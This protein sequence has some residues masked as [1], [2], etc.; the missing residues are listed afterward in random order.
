LLGSSVLVDGSFSLDVIVPAGGT[1]APLTAE[2][3]T[4]GSYKLDVPD[5][6]GMKQRL[7]SLSMRNFLGVVD[8]AL[9]RSGHTRR[10]IGYLNILHMKRS[11][12]DYVVNELGLRPDQTVYLS[13]YGHMGQQDQALSIRLGLE[14]GRL[15]D[16]DLM[17]MVAAG[18][19]YAW[20]ASVVQWGPVQPP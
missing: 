3:L 1:R 9:A 18:I 4:D 19:G 12:H 11:A 6:E 5:P 2:A 7:D 14:T 8:S 20:S 10:D 16:G 17:V 15:K 13:D